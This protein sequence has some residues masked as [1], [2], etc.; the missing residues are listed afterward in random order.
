MTALRQA[1]QL[2]ISFA[3]GPEDGRCQVV[4]VQASAAIEQPLDGRILPEFGNGR[5]QRNGTA[6]RVAEDCRPGHCLLNAEARRKDFGD[7]LGFESWR[8]ASET[9]AAGGDRRSA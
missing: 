3:D 2:G 9:G 6:F 4:Q 1:E 8:G 7:G 5:C